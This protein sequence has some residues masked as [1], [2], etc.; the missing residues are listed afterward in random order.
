MKPSVYPTITNGQFVV[1][2]ASTQTVLRIVNAV[3]TTLTQF[4]APGESF[5]HSIAGYSKGIYF[6]QL[7]DGKQ[8]YQFKIIKQ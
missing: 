1:S 5:T 2:G 3:G 4:T 6:I 7:L 8:L